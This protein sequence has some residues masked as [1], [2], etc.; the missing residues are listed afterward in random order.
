MGE[1]LVLGTLVTRGVPL[2]NIGGVEEG[3]FDPTEDL[4]TGE[5]GTGCREEEE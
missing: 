3:L 5:E 2:P 4:A 1:A